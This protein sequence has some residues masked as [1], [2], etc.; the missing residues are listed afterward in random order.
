MALQS[1]VFS[2]ILWSQY[3]LL[4]FDVPWAVVWTL[5]GEAMGV[6]LDGERVEDLHDLAEVHGLDKLVDLWVVE[7]MAEDKQHLVDVLGLRQ[8]DDKMAQVDEPRVHLDDDNECVRLQRPKDVLVEDALLFV[9]APHARQ[10]GVDVGLARS[11]TPGSGVEGCRGAAGRG[12]LQ[13][14]VARRRP[15]RP[16]QRLVARRAR[17][18]QQVLV[19]HLRHHGQDGGRV[20]AIRARGV[21][22]RAGAPAAAVEAG[23]VELQPDERHQ[24]EQQQSAAGRPGAAA[25]PRARRPTHWNRR[26]T[27]KSTR[28]DDIFQMAMNNSFLHTQKVDTLAIVSLHFETQGQS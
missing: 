21:A 1:Q 28:D 9:V 27:V 2:R 12:S 20:V 16:R 17:P 11:L 18:G 25:P 19:Q 5:P 22:R 8:A 26:N 3:L 7:V 24:E 4:L 14:V 10:H 15:G 13:A 6:C 23:Q